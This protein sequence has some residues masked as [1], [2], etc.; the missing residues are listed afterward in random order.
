MISNFHNI[1][2][3]TKNHFSSLYSKQ[4]ESEPSNVAYML[5]HISSIITN[6]ENIALNQPIYEADI[7]ATIWSLASDKTMGPDDFSITFYRHLWDLIKNDL[8][9]MLHYS[10][11]SLKLG[12]NTNSCFLSLVP[13]EANPTSF[14]RFRPISLCNTS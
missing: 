1:K 2:D 3:A 10:H 4:D 12:G 8:T 7:F 11:Q 13:K 5:E 6:E 14:S 9:C